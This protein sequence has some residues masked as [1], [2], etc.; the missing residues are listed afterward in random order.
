MDDIEIWPLMP[1]R[2]QHQMDDVPSGTML[3]VLWKSLRD[4]DST[5]LPNKASPS[6]TS[7]SYYLYSNPLMN[8][9]A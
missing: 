9:N 8:E 6:S 7:V 2:S 5:Q 4:F 3:A 1:L